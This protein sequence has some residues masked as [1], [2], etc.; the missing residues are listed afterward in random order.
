MSDKK[1]FP[2]L[3]LVLL[4]DPI[5]MQEPSHTEVLHSI[6]LRNIEIGIRCELTEKWSWTYRYNIV[7]CSERPALLSAPQPQTSPSSCTTLQLRK[8]NVYSG[9]KECCLPSTDRSIG[10]FCTA[11]HHLI[12]P[13]STKHNYS[14]A[15][16]T[17]QTS[18]YN[19][20]LVCTRSKV[21]WYIYVDAHPQAQTCCLLY[22]V[23]AYSAGEGPSQLRY[24]KESC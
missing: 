18:Q 3:W 20:F 21:M 13:N 19:A 15:I 22:R 14:C 9:G 4:P 23:Q 1:L 6:E 10:L 16:S 2:H 24:I 11:I 17:L 7:L 8:G 12:P 5:N